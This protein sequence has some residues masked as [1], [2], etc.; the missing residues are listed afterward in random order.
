MANSNFGNHHVLDA[1][2]RYDG[3]Q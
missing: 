1:E 3:P 2:I